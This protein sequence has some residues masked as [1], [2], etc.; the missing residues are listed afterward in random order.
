[1]TTQAYDA[2]GQSGWTEFV[3]VVMFGVG[4]F[5]II[6]ATAEFSNSRKLNDLISNHL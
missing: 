1:M 3:A 2:R 5:R 6:S 4:F